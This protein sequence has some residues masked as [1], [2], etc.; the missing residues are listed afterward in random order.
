MILT[1]EKLQELPIQ[2]DF[3]LRG[4][5]TARL[6]TFSDAPYISVFCKKTKRFKSK[7]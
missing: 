3:H 4:L 1:K 2:N 5:D 6:E 7:Q